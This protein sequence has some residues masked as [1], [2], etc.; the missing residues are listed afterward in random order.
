MNYHKDSFLYGGGGVIWH[1][2]KEK[3]LV[4]IPIIHFLSMS[5]GQADDFP[6]DFLAEV[7]Q[8]FIS[9]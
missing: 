5:G 3:M 6:E 7:N 4:R 8:R 9:G 2:W 1:P